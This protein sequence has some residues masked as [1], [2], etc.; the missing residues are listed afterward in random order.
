M[1][2]PDGVWRRRGHFLANLGRYGL[3]GTGGERDQDLLSHFLRKELEKMNVDIKLIFL[4]PH[5]PQ[6]N[7]AEV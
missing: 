2:V 3:L 7:P 1:L 5:T 6:L 4:P